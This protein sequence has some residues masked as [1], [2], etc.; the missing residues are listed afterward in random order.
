MFRLFKK[1]YAYPEVKCP[2][3]AREMTDEKMLL[4]NGGG[5]RRE[6]SHEGVAGANGNLSAMLGSV[7]TNTGIVNVTADKI[8]DYADDAARFTKLAKYSSGAS[9]VSFIT[10]DIATAIDLKRTAE[11]PTFENI[12]TL[13]GDL[14]GFIPE[15]GPFASAGV[16]YVSEKIEDAAQ[17]G[18]QIASRKMQFEYTI[19]SMMGNNSSVI[20]WAGMNPKY[21][22]NSSFL[23][24]LNWFFGKE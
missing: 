21:V 23:Q 19:D 20:F 6:N 7:S 18:I 12:S 5:E 8:I 16:S 2:R 1:K 14:V 24:G 17:A 10:G 13:T 22:I 9:K 15:I 3:N 4:V 11:N